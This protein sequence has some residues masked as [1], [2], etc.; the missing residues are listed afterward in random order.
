MLFQIVHADTGEAI[1]G[2]TFASA[3]EAQAARVM[4]E[5]AT[6]CKLRIAKVVE[7]I[8]WREREA[9]LFADG[10]RKPLPQWWLESPWW[11]NNAEIHADH[12][13]HMSQKQEGKI[14]F[15]ES[16]EKGAGDIQTV[17]SA[18]R[19]LARYFGLQRN[20]NDMLFRILRDEE[21]AAISARF[22]AGDVEVKIGSTPEAFEDVY[23]RAEYVCAENTS[24]RSCMASSYGR[25]P[26]HPAYVYGA[27]DLAIAYIEKENVVIARAVIWPERKEFVRIYGN[28]FTECVA[29]R[30]YL[31]GEGYTQAN[32]FVGAKLLKIPAHGEYLMPYI[33]GSDEEYKTCED[34]GEH[35]IIAYEGE[36]DCA[37]TGGTCEYGSVTHC[38]HC[39]SRIGRHDESHDVR[40]EMWCESCYESETFYCDYE[41]ETF[42][43]SAGYET[44]ITNNRYTRHQ[45]WNARAVQNNAFQCEATD[46]YYS[47]DDFTSIEVHTSSGVQIW[48][49]EVTEHN[50][51]ED[52]AGV[53]FARADFTQIEAVMKDGAAEIF[54]LEMPY[55]PIFKCDACGKYFVMALQGTQEGMCAECGAQGAQPCGIV[56]DSRQIGLSV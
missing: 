53:F 19:Y 33:D 15:T 11:V 12:F 18:S 50:F 30:T 25:F 56:E 40:G 16:P 35:F 39:E 55:E 21:I 5:S 23:R 36:I 28:T 22:E 52:V 32:H 34:S 48:C 42:P 41:E 6:G 29:L 7:N 45:T 10:T 46:T 20:K 27:G 4:H 51:F 43:Q 17:V 14:A 3:K 2:V 37:L 26:H 38:S 31:E 1:E 24:A 49:Y 13:P 8:A 47:C 9:S 54:C 44:V